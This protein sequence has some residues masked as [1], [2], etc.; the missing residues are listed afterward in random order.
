MIFLTGGTGF[1]GRY[2]VAELRRRGYP[3]RLLTRRAAD[4]P[5]LAALPDLE[6]VEGDLADGDLL[7][8]AAQG[9]RF[10]IHAGGRFRF[11]GD[12]AA[13]MATNAE[14]TRNVVEAALAVGVERF[15]H[16]STIAVIGTPDPA[17]IIDET[18]PPQPADP[19]QRS[20]LQGEQI[21]LDAW[22]A[23]GLPAV[24]LRPGAFYGPLGEYG[25]NRLFFRDPLRGIAMQ[26]SGG[27]YIIFPAYIADVAQG[28][29]LAL[30]RGQAGEIYHLCGGWITHREAFDIVYAEAGLWLPRLSFPGWA[31]VAFS[32]LLEAFSRLTG[33]EPF[34]PYNLKSYVYNYW[35]VSNAKARR[36]LGFVP[37]D[38]CEG[39][40]RT[41]RW[42]RAGCPEDG[43]PDV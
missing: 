10:V 2:L 1:L 15:L 39:A 40:R 32:R 14:G 16:I 12:E 13:F 36:E 42:Y 4:H 11:W 29:A 5:W 25:F 41:I 18:Y 3:L 19:Y 24:V 28:I 31:G 37:T 26:I 34:Y 35:R 9:C 43:E 27:R 7:R 17:Q 6:I 22:R 38:F 8:Q 33:R 23:R 21:V 20:K 30:E